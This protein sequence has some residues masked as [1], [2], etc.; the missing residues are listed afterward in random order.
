PDRRNNHKKGMSPRWKIAGALLLAF[1]GSAVCQSKYSWMWYD[2][3]DE[4]DHH[5]STISSK[6]CHTK[7]KEELVLRPDTVSQ[8]PVYN[9]LLNRIW[10]KN[11]T[12]LIHLHNMAL[13][14]AFFYSYILQKMNDSA[15]FYIQP[16]WLYMYMSATADV[17]ANPSMINGSAIYFDQDCHYPNWYQT[18]PFN[19]TLPL[20]GPKAWRWD[21]WQ[22]QS[23]ILR[24]P[25][26]RTATVVDLGAGQGMNYTHPMFKM[27]P[28]YGKWLPDLDGG[29]D[30]LTKFTYY[31]GIKYSNETGKFTKNE[32]EAF[33]FFGPSSPSAEE[34]DER[35]L[36]VVWTQPYYDCGIYNEWVISAVSPIVDYMPRYSI[37]THMRRQRIVGVI[38]MDT[39]FKKTDFNACSVGTGNPG[40]SYLSNIHR[41]R[42]TTNCKHRMGMGFKRGGYNCPCKTGTKYPWNVEP[43][44]K[45]EIIEQATDTEYFNSF[46]CEVSDCKYFVEGVSIVGGSSDV[47]SGGVQE[48]T[49]AMEESTLVN[50]NVLSRHIRSANT[51]VGECQEE[52]SIRR[53]VNGDVI[54]NLHQGQTIKIEN[55][56][57][58]EEESIMPA[59]PQVRI[60]YGMHHAV[61][62]VHDKRP[63]TTSQIHL[64]LTRRHLEAQRARTDNLYGNP[65]RPDK[66]SKPNLGPDPGAHRRRKRASVFDA[67]KDTVNK[68]NCHTVASHNLMLPGDVAYG[69]HTQFEVEAR[70]ALRLSH[71]LCNFLQNTDPSENFGNLR[72]GGRL[73]QEHVFG[74]VIAN[75]MGNF[76]IYSA[77]VFFDRYMFEN[78]DG[79][80]REFFGPWAY[81]KDGGYYAIDTAG[82]NTRYVDEEWFQTSKGRWATNRHGLEK[83]KMKPKIRSDPK[84]TSSVRHEHSSMSYKA[85][86]YSAGYWTRPQFKCDGKVDA[87]VVTYVTPFF[88]LD[89]LKRKLQFRGVVTVDV[90][91]NLLEINPCPQGFGVVNAFK[92]TARCDYFS[93]TCSVIAGY[94]FQR[95]SYKCACR[96]GFEYPHYDGREWFQGSLLESEYEKKI[97]GLYSRYD[98]L[99]C[100]TATAA[101]LSSSVALLVVA[102]LVPLARTKSLL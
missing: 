69:V 9:R 62:S 79:T 58:V 50:P 39:K 86:P 90:P 17:N 42:P 87:W 99:Y 8:L 84:G 47:I 26:R 68:D 61:E 65:A 40:P 32:F 59:R 94:P 81:R 33:P 38:V 75:V 67:K 82:L 25:T 93:T 5:F 36:P 100:R 21:D 74:E 13:N 76:K 24:E 63:I 11:R 23:N 98:Q 49:Q 77:G 7:A 72:G 30:S 1:L 64:A 66:G 19:N 73:H 92:N 3:Y 16:N 6:N 83:Y 43:P 46:T 18:V 10:Y 52:D 70:T 20:F 60:P 28:W 55:K 41:C 85:P 4:L 12:A 95:G 102:L 15:S 53:D 88:G 34:T 48:A 22:D 44:W 57:G 89:R 51:S 78:Q 2:Q 91:L 29:L 56:A 45:G 37:Y 97:R 80:K 31:V 71:F 54:W 101:R 27:N 35:K 96:Q 14:R